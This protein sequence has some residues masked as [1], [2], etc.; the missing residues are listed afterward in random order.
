MTKPDIEEVLPLTPLQEGLLFHASLDDA[1]PDLY[2]MRLVLDI[3]GPLDVDAL[4]RAGRAL[5]VRHPTLRA[6]FRHGGGARPLQFVPR[7]P[8][9]PLRHVDLRTEP[10]D[11][12]A[13]TDAESRHRFDLAAPPLL[14]ATVI[15]SADTRHRLVLCN[16]HILLDGWS[17]PVLV[18]ELFDLYHDEHADLPAVTPFRSYLAW[19]RRQDTAAARDAWA[20]NLDGLAEP[21]LIAP[22]APPVGQPD[23][24]SRHLSTA[25]TARLTAAARARGLTLATV[26]QGA[27][28]MLL[29][30]SRRWRTSRPRSPP[31]APR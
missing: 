25:A 18:R 30:S 8:D 11:L 16:H 24:V 13:V 2:T 21:T 3:D 4:A 7:E 6:G 9:F 15:T 29:E 17:G 27:W 23:R 26:L 12:A 19:L 10:G 14:R 31:R 22:D 1:E 20:A 28:G 5:L